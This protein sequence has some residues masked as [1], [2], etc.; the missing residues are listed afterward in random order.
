MSEKNIGHFLLQDTGVDFNS[1]INFANLGSFAKVSVPDQSIISWFL[2]LKFQSCVPFFQSEGEVLEGV[3]VNKH[4]VAITKKLKS[5]SDYGC[6]L[7]FYD[8]CQPILFN[9]FALKDIAFFASATGRRRSKN[10]KA[11]ISPK[12]MS[13]L[14]AILPSSSPLFC[15]C[16]YSFEMVLIGQKNRRKAPNRVDQRYFGKIGQDSGELI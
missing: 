13:S 12:A 16:R 7:D 2:C 10:K 5:L 4:L 6:T 14:F 9:G 3:I 15:A 1:R 8:I 11:V